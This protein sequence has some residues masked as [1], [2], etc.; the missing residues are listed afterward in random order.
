MAALASAS[1]VRTP[2]DLRRSG[3]VEPSR[4]R[5]G[6]NE[7]SERHL[8]EPRKH[9]AALGTFR[10]RLAPA[11]ARLAPVD[12]EVT[13]NERLEV[14]V[15]HGHR[16][17]VLVR[18][19]CRVLRIG[20]C[21]EVSR[22]NRLMRSRCSTNQAPVRRCSSRVR[23]HLG[24]HVRPTKKFHPIKQGSAEFGE[25]KLTPRDR[26]CPKVRLTGLTLIQE[27]VAQQDTEH[28]VQSVA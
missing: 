6:P 11:L 10:G 4:R 13:G 8:L 2:C 24:T 7:R 12:S 21:D 14:N 27:A 19:S 17:E 22:R 15:A 18:N 20:D 23:C 9:L 28:G 1:H 25:P 3:A 5:E 16:R 26:P